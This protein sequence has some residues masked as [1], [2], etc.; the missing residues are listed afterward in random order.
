MNRHHFAAIPLLLTLSSLS[1][2]TRADIKDLH[3][4]RTVDKSGFA[5]RTTIQAAVDSIAPPVNE[6]WTV[7]VYAGTYDEAVTLDPNHPNIDIVGVDPDAVIIAPPANTDAITIRG[8]GARNNTIRNLTIITSAGGGRG[9]V[10]REQTAN[11]NP[12]AVGIDGVRIRATSGASTGIRIEG[13]A[14]DVRITHCVIEAGNDSRGVWVAPHGVPSNFVRNLMIRDSRLLTRGGGTANWAIDVAHPLDGFQ[15]SNVYLGLD[16]P[17]FALRL[18][19]GSEGSKDLN[20]DGVVIRATQGGNLIDA[21]LAATL[22]MNNCD[23]LNVD[24]NFLVAVGD[25]TTI[26]NCSLVIDKDFGPN[27]IGHDDGAAVQ[28]AGKSGLCISSS[29]LHGREGG[30]RL[31]KNCR[32]VVVSNCELGGVFYGVRLECGEDIQ[33]QNCRLVADERLRRRDDPNPPPELPP[34][35]AA[36]WIDDRQT[37]PACQPGRIRLAACDLH[38]VNEQDQDRSVFGVLASAAP[39]AAAGP[40]RLSEC[41]IEARLL[42]AT[43]NGRCFG[44]AA[45]RAPALALLG[46]AVTSLDADEREPNQFDLFNNVPLF[47]STAIAVSGTRFSKWRGPIGPAVQASS[48][49]QRVVN[50]AAAADDA[51]LAATALTASEQEITTG[52]TNPDVYRV[53]S[54]R[55]N[56]AVMNQ[57]VIVVGTNAAG[58]SIADAITLVGTTAA[59]GVKPFR[60]VRKIILPPQSGPGQQVSVG[61]TTWLGLPVPFSSTTDLLQQARLAV[62]AGSYTVEPPGSLNPTWSTVDVGTIIAGDSFEFTVQARP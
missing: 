59:S 36:L 56:Q 21:A 49:V 58:E 25:H 52:I 19:S 33:L 17:G 18:A 46:G 40:V 7:L 11:G 1:V 8:D 55:G 38:A 51:V 14:D 53:L 31:L 15:L 6:K 62:G 13:A 50:V 32:D 42:D 27:R 20:L 45:L 29:R 24:A 41:T 34:Q 16:A 2:S 35:Y 60:S 54:V 57:T 9:I 5:D 30:L 39:T 28:A 26:T 12:S 3:R 23:I 61:T 22:R 4:T 37:D 48:L 10:I 43:S 44:A 47:P